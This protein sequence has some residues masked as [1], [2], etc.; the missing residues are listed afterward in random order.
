MPNAAT[1]V[2]AATAHGGTVLPPGVPTV[3]VA[4]QAAAVATLP[5][6][7]PLPGHAQTPL[8]PGSGTVLIGGLPALRVGDAATCGAPVVVGAPTVLIGG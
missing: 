7:C 6:A 4:G 1:F 3:L 8:V 2:G 5:H